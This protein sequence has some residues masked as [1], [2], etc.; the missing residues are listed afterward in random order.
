MI[1]LS[2]RK[3]IKKKIMIVGRDT[4]TREGKRETNG[5]RIS[6]GGLENLN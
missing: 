2:P 4:T 6:P 1:E 3:K 5:M